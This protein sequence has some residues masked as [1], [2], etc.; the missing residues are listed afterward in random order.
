MVLLFSN[1]EAQKMVQERQK[2]I[3]DAKK[4]LHILRT[5]FVV[6]P[7]HAKEVLLAGSFDGWTSQVRSC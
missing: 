7:N 6:W 1:R 2:R 4:A 3:D 5:A